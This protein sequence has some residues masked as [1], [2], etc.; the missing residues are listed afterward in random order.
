MEVKEIDCGS[1]GWYFDDDNRLFLDRIEFLR[2]F[3]MI[4][5]KYGI[6]LSSFGISNGINGHENT[7]QIVEQIFQIVSD[8]DESQLQKAINYNFYS[9]EFSKRIMSSVIYF[10]E[11]NTPIQD[12]YNDFFSLFFCTLKNGKIFSF[13]Y[14]MRSNIF[15][16]IDKTDMLFYANT[17]RHNSY[18]RCMHQLMFKFG[19]TLFNYSDGEIDSSYS[20]CKE[21]YINYNG[22]CVFYED[23]YDLI[24]IELRH[25]PVESISFSFEK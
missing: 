1:W 24:P 25:T 10:K 2:S 19:A 7:N 6:N 11:N 8:F 20:I 21:G 4:S 9:K 18:I 17:T 13:F 12:I 14:N 16:Q 3:L 22:E 5:Y 15:V 23:I